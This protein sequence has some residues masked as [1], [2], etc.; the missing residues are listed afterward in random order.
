MKKRLFGMLLMLAVLAAVCALSVSAVDED[1]FTGTGY[2]EA[3]DDTVS[4]QPL[5]QELV[6]AWNG[7]YSTANG[8]HYYV[9][10]TTV[11]TPKALT[12]DTGEVLHL[13]LK[14]NTFK[15]GGVRAITV[16]GELAVMDHSANKGVLQAGANNTSTGG[17]VRL[18]KSGAK[19]DL[20]G[21]T[22]KMVSGTN[23]EADN[24]GC[25]YQVSGTTFNMHGGALSGGKSDGS[26]GS[27][28]YRNGE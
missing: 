16:N 27:E 5:T 24:G 12:V 28:N 6:T 20:Y 22:V 4:W 8:T 23:T 3:C 14:G 2:C 1:F 19:F 7:D 17:V 10:E 11:T 13:H 9:S 25:V 15:R 21:G 26:G 18:N